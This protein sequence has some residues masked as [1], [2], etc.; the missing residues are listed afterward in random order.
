MCK[1]IG[2]AVAMTIAAT[3]STLCN[4]STELAAHSEAV[5]TTVRVLPL[6]ILQSQVRGLLFK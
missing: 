4:R 2:L 5:A 1:I 6:D 3:G